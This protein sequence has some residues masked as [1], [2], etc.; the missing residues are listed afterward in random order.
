MKSEFVNYDDLIMSSFYVTSKQ[1]L[2]R[3]SEKIT[4][5]INKDIHF[6]YVEFPAKIFT[7]L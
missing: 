2:K 3:N 4:R 6:I 5:D 7:I 1:L